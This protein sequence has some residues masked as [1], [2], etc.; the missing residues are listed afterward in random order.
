[1]EKIM[2]EEKGNLAQFLLGDLDGCGR[3]IENSLRGNDKNARLIETHEDR[4]V[5]RAQS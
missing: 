2:L 5:R 4:Q 3:P 1:M